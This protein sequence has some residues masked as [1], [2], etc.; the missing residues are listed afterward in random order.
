MLI[1]GRTNVG[2]TRNTKE[3]CFHGWAGVSDDYT[4]T[5]LLARS[6][7]GGDI[8]RLRENDESAEKCRAADVSAMDR[9]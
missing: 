8:L 6:A 5:L 7:E 3:L 9:K 4:G 1:T 2:M